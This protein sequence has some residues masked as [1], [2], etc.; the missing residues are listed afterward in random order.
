MPSPRAQRDLKIR[1]TIRASHARSQGTYGAP[2]ILEDLRDAG[3]RVGKKRVAR[4]MQ[5]DGLCGVSK[6][7]K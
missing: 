2:R 4:L 5:H 1:V 3:Y 6:T 7:S